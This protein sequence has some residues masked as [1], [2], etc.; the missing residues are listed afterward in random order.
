MKKYSTITVLKLPNCRINAFGIMQ[1]ADMMTNIGCLRDLNLDMNP[2]TQEN[3]HLLCSP[4]GNLWYLSLKLCEISDDGMMKIANEL[5]YQDPP[6]NPKLII[7]NL[8]NNYITKN[9]AACI[10]CMLRSN[11]S[12]KSLV[13]LGNRICDEGASLIIRELKIITLTHEEI[14][15]LRRRKF[16][17]LALQ[18][19]LESEEISKP[20]D[21]ELSTKRNGKSRSRQSLNKRSRKSRDS[22]IKTREG[23]SILQDL[24]SRKEILLVSES[25][26]FRNESF[27]I[28][29]SIMATGNLELQ[30]LD[31]GY[32]YLTIGT[33]KKLIECLR[34]QNY[35]LL[36]DST[37]GI[38][39]CFLENGNIEKKGNEDWSTYEELLRMRQ[40]GK[41]FANDT[42][43][44][45]MSEEI[46]ILRKNVKLIC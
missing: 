22:L 16:A 18:E 30:H 34:Y 35:M 9:G 24:E 36:G 27:P 10:G 37:K 20:I 44:E 3:F 42:F 7:L 2:N 39:H 25:H 12:L 33:L 11:R 45:F 46:E 40:D 29:D 19:K 31:L 15:D 26:P 4:L 28:N 1:I 21:E 5:R 14:M 38:L 6:N 43:R 41:T 32:N 17:Q 8:A 23:G 13:L